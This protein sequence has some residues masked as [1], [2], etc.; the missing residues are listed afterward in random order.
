MKTI[1]Q[2]KSLRKGCVVPVDGREG[3]AFEDLCAVDISQGG[4]GFISS[5]PVPIHKKIAVEVE[6][7]RGKDPVLMMAEVKWVRPLE[8]S[9]NFR[10]GMRF[11]KVLYSGSKSRLTQYFQ[12]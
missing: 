12:E 8:Q 11:I 5:K 1:E 6:L 2:R 4:L 9:Q 7:G 10:I 3:G